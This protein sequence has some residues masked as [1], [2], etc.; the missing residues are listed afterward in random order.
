PPSSIL[1]GQGRESTIEIGVVETAICP[2]SSL[3]RFQQPLVPLLGN[4]PQVRRNQGPAF[5]V[6]VTA[7]NLPASGRT[8]DRIAIAPVF[9]AQG[10]ELMLQTLGKPSA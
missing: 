3:A 4:R 6:G 8:E 5:A 2:L 9:Q 10:T 1:P 7:I